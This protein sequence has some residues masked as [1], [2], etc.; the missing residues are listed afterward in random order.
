MERI[1]V[2]ASSSARAARY[3][4]IEV[5]RGLPIAFLVKYFTQAGV[6]WQLRDEP[7]RMVRFEQID[8]RT[9]LRA[10]GT[11][12]LIFCRNVMIYFDAQTRF[13]LLEQLRCCLTEGGWLLLG[14]AETADQ[15]DQW[16]ERRT[17]AGATIYRAK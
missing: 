1:C 7:R 2:P 5:N 16:F 9:D 6:E 12:D 14:G 15:I 4:Q 10:L 11:F 17:F 8:L 13:R 3:Q